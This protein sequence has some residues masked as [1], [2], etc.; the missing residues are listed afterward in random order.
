MPS[1][2]QK[3]H[4]KA[5]QTFYSGQRGEEPALS[6]DDEDLKAHFVEIHQQFSQIH[7]KKAVDIARERAQT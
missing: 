3:T 7:G 1:M 4:F 6:I 2:H 5:S